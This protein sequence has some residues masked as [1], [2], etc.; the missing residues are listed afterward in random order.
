MTFF[1]GQFGKRDLRIDCLYCK[2]KYKCIRI[3]KTCSVKH[4]FKKSDALRCH[5]SDIYLGFQ[6]GSTSMTRVALVS[7]NPSPPTCAVSKNI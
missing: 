2:W 7:V 6:A 3:K 4:S 5:C 1:S